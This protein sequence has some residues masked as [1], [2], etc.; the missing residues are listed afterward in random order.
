MEL[1]GELAVLG[2]RSRPAVNRRAGAGP[3]DDGHWVLDGAATT[4]PVVQDS[5]FE[6][7]AGDRVGFVGPNGAGKTTF[8]KLL[9][10]VDTPEGGDI[11]YHAGARF[12]MLQQV[13]EFAPGRTVFA[14]AKSAFDYQSDITDNDSVFS[15]AM[16]I[17]GSC[18]LKI[19][20]LF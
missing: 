6:L 20:T 1:R 10:G 11:R 12:G 5:P 9:S 3:S 17:T 15:V 14:E 18:Q 16:I 2:I 4:L 7:H 13:A 19:E 8:M